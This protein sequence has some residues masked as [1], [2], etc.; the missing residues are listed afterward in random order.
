[1]L[2]SAELLWKIFNKKKPIH[3]LDDSSLVSHK[4]SKP[5]KY[6]LFNSKSLIDFDYR[7]NK[8]N[9][10]IIGTLNVKSIA[11][12]DLRIKPIHSIKR[13]MRFDET[14]IKHLIQDVADK[15]K[16]TLQ[17]LHEQIDLIGMKHEELDSLP[18]SGDYYEEVKNLKVN[19]SG[20][21]L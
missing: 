20:M 12:Y 14:Q 1:L 8:T 10:L 21:T 4:A 16:Q 3:G 6:D 19:T 5:C 18:N 11:E 7:H 13:T 17:S 9:Q 15:R 2:F